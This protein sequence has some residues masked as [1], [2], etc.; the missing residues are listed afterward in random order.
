M[1]EERAKTDEERHNPI[2]SDVWGTQIPLPFD[3]EAFT[4]I[5]LT[6][7]SKSQQITRN[8]LFTR[9]IITWSVFLTFNSIAFL[10]KD[11]RPDN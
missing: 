6:F 8:I 10:N 5:P 3:I 1:N 9:E 2:S 7:C 4:K 11:L